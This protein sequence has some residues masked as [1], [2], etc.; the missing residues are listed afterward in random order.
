MSGLASN[1]S[2]YDEASRLAAESLE[3]YRALDYPQGMATCMTKLGYLDYAQGRYASAHVRFD[4]ALE[5]R[6]RAGQTW[7]TAD[8]LTYMAELAVAE[9]DYTRAL[10]LCDEIEPLCEEV[11]DAI[12]P[13]EIRS[14]RARATLATAGPNA[15]RAIVMQAAAASLDL[16]DNYLI[17]QCHQTAVALESLADDQP[18]ALI[19]LRIA[20]DHMLRIQDSPGLAECLELAARLAAQREDYADSVRLYATAGAWRREVG[21]PPVPAV[22]ALREQDLASARSALG[23]AG[24]DAAEA[25]GTTT[26][27]TT[28]AADLG[29]DE[30]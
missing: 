24:F 9:G 18:A 23:N 29:R 22:A 30:T 27:L 12:G 25:E 6:R 28:A 14:I 26:S 4:E 17:A 20:V 1:L 15:G 3:L 5:L 21:A 8:A 10:E 16:G 2:R 13:V 19:N 11:G 7:L